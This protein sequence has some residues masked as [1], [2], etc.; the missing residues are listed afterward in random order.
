MG[1]LA[2]SAPGAWPRF[3]T[4]SAKAR[5]I[6]PTLAAPTSTIATEPWAAVSTSTTTRSLR[7]N[8]PGTERTPAAFTGNS[9]PGT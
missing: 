2:G 3:V 8:S 6:R 5:L 7:V 1:A 9:R 4:R